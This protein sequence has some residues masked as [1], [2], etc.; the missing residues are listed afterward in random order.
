MSSWVT[1]GDLAGLALLVAALAVTGI[2]AFAEESAARMR[3]GVRRAARRQVSRF[4]RAAAAG[5]ADGLP[6]AGQAVAAPSGGARAGEAVTASGRAPGAQAG[7]VPGDA[8]SAAGTAARVPARAGWQASPA[9]KTGTAGT[10]AGVPWQHQPAWQHPADRPARQRAGSRPLV[11]D[12]VPGP[13]A[14]QL[15][16]SVSPGDQ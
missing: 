3:A 16:E 11:E 4:R 5:R 13:A 2:S 14:L 1:A 6:G 12:R 9:R 7:P 8:G 10:Q 15:E